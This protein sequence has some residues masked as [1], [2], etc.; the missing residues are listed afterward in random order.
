MVASQKNH[1]EIHKDQNKAF[2]FASGVTKL[3]VSLATGVITITITFGSNSLTGQN[4]I[5][6]HEGL[7]WSWI[8]LVLSIFTGIC[9]MM[10]MTGVLSKEEKPNVYS[11]S[12]RFWEV[13][14]IITFIIGIA[15]SIAFTYEN[16]TVGLDDKSDKVY[17]YDGVIN[18]TYQDKYN[19][20]KADTFSINLRK[21]Y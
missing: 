12:I 9:A 5:V 4:D 15:L 19:K 16:I 3:L 17:D 1:S 8:L 13:L 2:D 10:A 11:C 7:L 20:L 14:Q 6:W 18:K 21:N